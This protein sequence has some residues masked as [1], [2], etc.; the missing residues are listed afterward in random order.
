M[1]LK[2]RKYYRRTGARSRIGS[3]HTLVTDLYFILCS[4]FLSYFCLLPGPQQLESHWIY[5][6]SLMSLH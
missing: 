4:E 5:A 6:E 1:D 2:Q 3:L